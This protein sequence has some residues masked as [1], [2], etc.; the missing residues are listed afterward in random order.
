VTAPW[1]N[2]Y[3]GGSLPVANGVSLSLMAHVGLRG[4]PLDV[5]AGDTFTSE[6]TAP[7][8]SDHYTVEDAIVVGGSVGM[9]FDYDLFERA[10]TSIWDRISPRGYFTSSGSSSARSLPEGF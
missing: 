8:L 7:R 9:S 10:F 2:F 5:R 4:V 6:S 1:E 3:L